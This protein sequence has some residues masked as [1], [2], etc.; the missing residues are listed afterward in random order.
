MSRGVR[1]VFRITC[2]IMKIN[3]KVGRLNSYDAHTDARVTRFARGENSRTTLKRG[4]I[5]FDI[6]SAA[7][8]KAFRHGTSES[9]IRGIERRAVPWNLALSA[10]NGLVEIMATWSSSR[11]TH[12]PPRP[13]LRGSLR[14]RVTFAVSR[15]S[16]SRPTV[17]DVASAITQDINAFFPSPPPLTATQLSR[18]R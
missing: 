16:F 1:N 12:R 11:T 2:L 18:A 3:R 13:T 10:F 6:S 17:R 8:R 14:S 15:F 9:L 4:T 7:V 5:A